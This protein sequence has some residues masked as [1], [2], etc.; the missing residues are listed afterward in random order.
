MATPVTGFRGA[1]AALAALIAL[2]GCALNPVPMDV[3]NAQTV[4][5]IEPSGHVIMTELFAGGAGVGTGA[6][7]L[8]GQDLPIQA[9]RHCDRTWRGGEAR[10]VGRSLQAR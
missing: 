3:P 7:D 1:I 8:Q 5:G 4:A 6:L 10:R 2:G 9:R